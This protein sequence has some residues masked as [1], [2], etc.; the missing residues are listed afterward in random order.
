[1]PIEKD[2]QNLIMT[3]M[4]TRFELRV[5]KNLHDMGWGC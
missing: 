4:L 5:L 3:S 1:M 2:E